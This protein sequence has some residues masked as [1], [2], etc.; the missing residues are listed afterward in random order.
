MAQT[1]SKTAVWA[2]R[3]RNQLRIA[4]PSRCKRRCRAEIV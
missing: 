4:H 3:L 2:Q 1:V